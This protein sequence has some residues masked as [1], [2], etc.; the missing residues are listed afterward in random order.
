MP[1][2]VECQA[3]T[4]GLV[5][6]VFARGATVEETVAIIDFLAEQPAG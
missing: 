4:E 2:Y 6:D 1:G 5:Y 3:G